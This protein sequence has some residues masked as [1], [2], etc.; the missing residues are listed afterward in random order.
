[1]DFDVN[2]D[3]LKELDTLFQEEEPATSTGNDSDESTGNEG[4]VKQGTPE[5]QTEPEKDVTTTKIFSKRLKE[6]TAAAVMKER[7][8]IAKRMG[9]SSYDEMIK[10]QD[11]QNLANK[12]L[13]PEMAAPI[14]EEI[15]NK[16]IENDPRMQKVAQYEQSQAME[17]AKNELSKITALTNGRI[18]KFEQLPKD[19][20]D[21]WR[22]SGD[23]K[24]SYLKLHGEELIFQAQSNASKGETTH[25]AN[26]GTNNGGN[27][28]NK[29]HLTAEERK[30]WKLFHP[31]M[32]E[33]ELNKKLVEK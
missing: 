2:D 20:L 6:S 18:T 31:D 23:L 9:Y 14:I 7:E 27:L 25:L 21:D 3:L 10:E 19:V 32:T 16:R 12:G 4:T 5:P 30:A 8:E 22:V 33:D 29:R 11:K 13:D 15:V 17:F 28:G 24:G 1:M 26:P